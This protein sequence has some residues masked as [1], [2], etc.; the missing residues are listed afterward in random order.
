MNKR[1]KQDCT[2]ATIITQS[3]VTAYG[4]PLGL[5]NCPLPPIVAFSSSEITRHPIERAPSGQHN[6][7]PSSIRKGSAFCERAITVPN[8]VDSSSK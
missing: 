1:S 4:P 2:V 6:W 8:P 3:K 5:A 7:P